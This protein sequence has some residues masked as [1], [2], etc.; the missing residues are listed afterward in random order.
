MLH[1]AWLV[2]QFLVVK[3]VE[4]LVRN[5][6]TSS[7]TDANRWTERSMPSNMLDVIW[8]MH[9]LRP[10]HYL[11]TCSALLGTT[12]VI[13]HTPGYVSKKNIPGSSLSQKM[14]TLFRSHAPLLYTDAFET[15]VINGDKTSWIVLAVQDY[16]DEGEG[17]C[18]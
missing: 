18:G 5:A 1:P 17:D 2:L 6:S 15:Q 3:A 11:S 13:D 9:M 7:I 8:H 14:D 16:I 4:A 12:D 10:K